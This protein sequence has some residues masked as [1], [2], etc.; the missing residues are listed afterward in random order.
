MF[1]YQ[2]QLVGLFVCIFPLR[3]FKFRNISWE[4]TSY[5]EIWYVWETSASSKYPHEG[6]PII[7][8]LLIKISTWNFQCLPL[9]QTRSSIT[10]WMTLSSKSPVRN[11][12]CTESIPMKYPPFLT[13]LPWKF[14]VNIFII[15]V[16]RMGG[17]GVLHGDTW[18]TLRV[19][20]RR[21]GWQGHPWCNGWS[22]LTQRK[23]LKVSCW[24]LY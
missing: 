1:Q 3:I 24:Y 10:P 8:A 18:S 4:I 11:P 13:H 9:G 19:P 5:T 20:D 15:S 12:Q 17:R 16:S 14:C 23:T 21:F 2:T 7:D 22:W 6:P